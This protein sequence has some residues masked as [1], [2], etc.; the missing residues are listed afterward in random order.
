MIKEHTQSHLAA[1]QALDEQRTIVELHGIAV[2]P[3][4][5]ICG[6][7]WATVRQAVLRRAST[8]RL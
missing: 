8:D 7:G 2:P 6:L 3:Y 4:E 5:Y 1:E